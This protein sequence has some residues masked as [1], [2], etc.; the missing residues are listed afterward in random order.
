MG[1]GIRERLRDLTALTVVVI[2]LLPILWWGLTSLKPV[3]AIFNKDETIVLGFVP[4][5][6]NYVIAIG[7][8][9][10]D[11]LSA[12]ATFMNS[13]IIAAG[14]TIISV[15][16]GLMAAFG[17]TRLGLRSARRWIGFV[18]LLRM[19]PPIAIIIPGVML[20]Q[21]VG[22]FDTRLA[23]ILIHALMNLPLAVLMLLSFLEDVPREVDEAAYLDGADSKVLFFRILLPMIMGGIAATAT[24]CALFSWTEFLISLFLSVS[25]RTVPVQ[26]SILSMGA[27]G[28][29]AAAGTLA[30]LPAFCAILLLQR[31]IVRGLTLGSLR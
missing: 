10:P 3:W 16:A 6:T 13:M 8:G 15:G 2:F 26:L 27:W 29:L 5:L 21:Q 23:V 12:R 24:L 20:S 7:E 22:L 4:S 1:N 31:H 30:M 9:G 28:P 19:L 18:V 25:F 11:A 14:S 17:L